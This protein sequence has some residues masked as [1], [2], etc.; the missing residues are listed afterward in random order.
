M[1]SP[2]INDDVLELL[3]LDRLPESAATPVEEHRLLCAECRER[4]AGWDAYV[5][6]MR[7]ALTRGFDAH[8]T[9]GS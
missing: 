6:A 2:H 5:Q 4:Q 3:A 1:V 8:S 7:A 9:G